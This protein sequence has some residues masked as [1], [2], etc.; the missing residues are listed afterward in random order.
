MRLA[1]AGPGVFSVASR[2]EGLE[3]GSVHDLADRIAAIRRWLPSIPGEAMTGDPVSPDA[4]T[5]PGGRETFADLFASHREDL[6]L[7]CRRMLDDEASVDDALSEV[8][9][10]AHR[11]L[12]KYDPRKPFKPWIR[13]LAANHCIDQLRRRKTERGLFEP[14]DFATDFAADDAPGALLRITQKE[15]RSEVIAAL[16]VLPAKY[17]LPLVL[18]FY[19]DL[20][21]EEIAAALGVTR[22]QVGTL[23]FRAK[24]KLR[25]ELLARSGDDREASRAQETRR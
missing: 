11:A 5:S 3:W 7:L 21:Y 23:L 19:R 20:D 18:R 24:K 14:T 8:F 22:S 10:R 25:G 6:R 4:P 9:L 16:D 12:P 17:R 13:T 15:E 1:A 2:S